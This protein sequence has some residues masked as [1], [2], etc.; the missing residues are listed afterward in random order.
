MSKIKWILYSNSWKE[1]EPDDFVADIDDADPTIAWT[2]A[3]NTDLTVSID[4]NRIATITIPS[5]VNAERSLFEAKLSK[6]S[7]IGWRMFILY[8]PPQHHLE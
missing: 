5:I 6:A 8:P 1:Y 3:G 2:Y 4:V 7:T